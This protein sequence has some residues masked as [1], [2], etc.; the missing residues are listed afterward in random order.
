[1]VISVVGRGAPPVRIEL[2]TS[3]NVRSLTPLQEIALIVAAT[4]RRLS[5]LITVGL[6]RV[7]EVS[8]LLE[9][10]VEVVVAL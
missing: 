5:S 7:D 3:P 2:S 1:M 6:L 4:S 9:D 8:Q 10:D